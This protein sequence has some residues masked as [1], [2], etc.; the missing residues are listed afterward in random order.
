MVPFPFTDLSGQKVRPALVISESTEENDVIVVFISSKIPKQISHLDIKVDPD[1]EN[2]LK[3]VSLVKCA[4]IATLD[5]KTILGEL[6][7]IN[8]YQKKQV[9]E[10]LREVFGFN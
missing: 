3:T 10:K 1:K 5:I 4:R 2:H 6:G 9:R 7:S 8:Q